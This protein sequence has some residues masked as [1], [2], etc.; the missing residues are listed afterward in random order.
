MVFFYFVFIMIYSVAFKIHIFISSITLLAGI[1]TIAL[2]IQGL[3]RKREYG[4]KD[5]VLSVVFNV[6]L[7]LQLILGF[8]KDLVTGGGSP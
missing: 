1:F 4:R 8:L 7:Y 5:L 2:S 6:A 3:I